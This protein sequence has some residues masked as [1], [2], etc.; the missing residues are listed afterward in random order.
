MRKYQNLIPGLKTI[1]NVVS[2]LKRNIAGLS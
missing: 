1:S 2:Y